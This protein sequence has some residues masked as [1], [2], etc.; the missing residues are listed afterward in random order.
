MKQIASQEP[1][2]IRP[3]LGHRSRCNYHLSFFSLLKSCLFWKFRHGA[4]VVL[5]GVTLGEH[6]MYLCSLLPFFVPLNH[7][8][9]RTHAITAT[10]APFSNR[11]LIV[12]CTTRIECHQYPYFSNLWDDSVRTD[13]T[14]SQFVPRPSL[15]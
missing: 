1:P 7:S 15:L 10:L 14:S 2:V 13:S 5:V 3:L 4:S 11:L 6:L 9:L 12:A 8:I